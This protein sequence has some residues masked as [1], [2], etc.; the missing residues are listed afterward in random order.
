MGEPAE[1]MTTKYYNLHFT[2]LSIEKNK[3]NVSIEAFGKFIRSIESYCN[4]HA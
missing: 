4:M 1:L 2:A 3:L